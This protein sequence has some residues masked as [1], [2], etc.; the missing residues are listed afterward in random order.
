MVLVCEYF[1][2]F[3]F[4]VKGAKYDAS[5]AGVDLPFC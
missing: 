5:D 4:A 3:S 1:G 2:G